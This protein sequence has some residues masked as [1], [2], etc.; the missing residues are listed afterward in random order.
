MHYS[1]GCAWWVQ[2]LGGYRLL[3]LVN[4]KIALSTRILQYYVY[5]NTLFV[6]LR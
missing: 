5:V 1:K 6:L 4:A 3:Y 2:P